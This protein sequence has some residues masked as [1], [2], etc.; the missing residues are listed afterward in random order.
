MPLWSNNS[1]NASKP[2]YTISV[3]P[4]NNNANVYSVNVSQEV[5]A[6]VSNQK[7]HGAHQGW[8]KIIPEYT[9][10]SGQVRRKSETLVV[11]STPITGAANTRISGTVNVSN[12]NI[13]I[14]A[15]IT[16]GLVAANTFILTS[17]NVIGIISNTDLIYVGNVGPLT[18]NVFA[19]QNVAVNA[20]PVATVATQPIRFAAGTY[21]GN[22][23]VVGSNLV[24]NGIAGNT[25]FFH[26][27][28]VGDIIVVGNVGDV[29]QGNTRRI[30]SINANNGGG[31]FLVV[32]AA[33]ANVNTGLIVLVSDTNL[34]PNT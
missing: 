29:F 7:F 21:K 2:K 18:C 3:D 31:Q 12:G 28:K 6:N 23:S 8:V 32:N 9:D 15:N 27:L 22:T 25:R 19:A 26:E 24:D 14:S 17:A 1:N 11:M 4:L 33:F 10:S 13:S 5:L 16:G 20:A 30:V 34:F